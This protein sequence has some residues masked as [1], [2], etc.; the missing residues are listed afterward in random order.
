[1]LVTGNVR[2]AETGFQGIKVKSIDGK[3]QSL[4][5]YKGK[6][7]LVVNVASECGLTGQYAGLE[8]LYKKYKDKGF[9]VLGFPCNDFGEQEP[10]AEK[11]IKLFCQTRY[12]VTFPMFAKV[13]ITGQGK[14][15][16]YEQL[17]GKSSPFPGDVTWNFAKFLV[18]KD[19]KILKRFDPDVE[20]D[21]EEMSK[22]VEA[23]LA[24][25]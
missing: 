22:A 5:E 4:G 21:T 25:K 9:V 12:Q 8:E 6:V 18:G 23:A 10:G 24:A 7:W 16:L 11:E 14:H 3:E 17:T 19:G 1:M 20:P 2:S 13:K 15:P